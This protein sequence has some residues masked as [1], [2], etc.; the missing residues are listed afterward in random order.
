MLAIL[1]QLNRNERKYSTPSRRG[2]DLDLPIEWSGVYSYHWKKN[3]KICYSPPRAVASNPEVINRYFDL[4]E[5]TVLENSLSNKPSQ[6]FNLDETG[7]PLASQFY[8]QE[9]IEAF[10]YCGVWG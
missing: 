1:L 3:D 6:I 5:Q 10:F 7:M 9:G 8:C 4:L 2:S